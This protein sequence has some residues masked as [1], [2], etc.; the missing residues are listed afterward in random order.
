MNEALWRRKDPCS[1]TEVIMS[2]HVVT[3]LNHFSALRLDLISVNNEFTNKTSPRVKKQC[4]HWKKK[5]NFGG[6]SNRTQY[7]QYRG[8]GSCT[9]PSDTISEDTLIC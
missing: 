5:D 4:T 6:R 1:L 8:D 2:G 7:V 3:G 9:H